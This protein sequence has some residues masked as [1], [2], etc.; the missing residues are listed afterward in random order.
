MELTSMTSQ[1]ILPEVRGPI[2]HWSKT[3]Q[4]GCSASMAPDKGHLREELGWITCVAWKKQQE[5]DK[6]WRDKED[7]NSTYLSPIKHDTHVI[8]PG[9]TLDINWQDSSKRVGNPKTSR[10]ESD[11]AVTLARPLH[12]S[13]VGQS[14]EKGKI[15]QATLISDFHADV[16]TNSLWPIRLAQS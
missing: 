2:P 12:V 7:K 9:W 8:G 14:K 1:S 16:S 5:E 4:P 15:N 3:Q 13:K 10:K 11:V 6:R